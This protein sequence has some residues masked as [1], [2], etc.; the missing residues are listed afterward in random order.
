LIVVSNA[1]ACGLPLLFFASATSSSTP[2][3]NARGF[4]A[5]LFPS[6]RTS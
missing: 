1:M 6:P 2:T 3:A 5:P 4:D